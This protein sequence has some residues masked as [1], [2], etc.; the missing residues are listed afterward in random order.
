MATYAIGDIQGCHRELLNL[1]DLVAFSAGRDKLWLCGDLVN[2]GPQSRATL[3]TVMAFGDDV[4]TVLGNHD[5]H[6]LAV[7]LTPGHQPKKRD[8]LDDILSSSRKLDYLDW[9][10][11][12]PLFHVD[13]TLNIAMVHAGLPPQWTVNDARARAAE[14]ETVLREEQAART[15]LADMYGDGPE[16]WNERLGGTERLRYIV[17]C[18]TRLR[19]CSADG[20]LDLEEK[21][22]PGERSDGLQPWF[23]FTARR[24]RS[25][26]L[27]FGH[28]STLRVS[29]ADCQRHR[30]YPLDTGAVWGDR[31]TAL[32]LED[33]RLFSVSSS[34]R[35]PHA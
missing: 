17:N 18:M 14:V 34:V 27:V 26:P 7:A 24:S 23:E 20:R 8:T 29:A 3:D 15:F 33:K 6:L 32:R 13:Q 28:W 16:H 12:Q 9:L 1:L 2:R 4:I 35:V 5:L 31:L 19:L 30:V 21:G 11:H 22:A 10:R 25:T